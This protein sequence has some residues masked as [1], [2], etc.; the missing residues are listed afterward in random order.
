MAFID[1]HTAKWTTHEISLCGRETVRLALKLWDSGLQRESCQASQ[2]GGFGGM[3]WDYDW[4]NVE[5]RWQS[6]TC[7]N[8]FH[9]CP[10][11]RTTLV[12]LSSCWLISQ[13]ALSGDEA[14]ETVI[15]SLEERK[16]VGRLRRVFRTVFS[17]HISFNMSPV[18]LRALRGYLPS[19]G[20]NWW[21]LASHGWGKNWSSWNWTNQTGHSPVFACFWLIKTI[22][23][24]N[25]LPYTKEHQQYI[26]WNGGMNQREN[27]SRTSINK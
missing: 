11:R 3:P 1:I 7:M 5:V 19:N 12:W 23:G 15:I 25:L 4:A 20:N 13:A 17:H 26:W 9:F 10:L 21:W 6:F 22:A 8:I 18:C 14:W 2:V 27:I 24:D 16:V